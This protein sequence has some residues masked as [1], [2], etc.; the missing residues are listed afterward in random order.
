MRSILQNSLPLLGA[1]L[2][3]VLI[4]VTVL[5]IPLH[6]AQS[7]GLSSEQLT[8]WIVALYGIP[9]ILGIIL[10]VRF[11]QP[12]A[13]TSNLFA[14]IFFASLGGEFSWSELV[15]ASMLA[16]G[17]VVLIGVLGLAGPLARWIPTPIML[18]L[19]AG[20]VLPFIIDI[21]TALGDETL[22]VG[23]AL[24]AYLVG[25]RFLS[26][27]LPP[28][29]PAIVVGLLVAGLAGKLGPVPTDWAFP[30]PSI[31]TPT[32]SLSAIATVTPVVT[33]LMTLQAN[34]PSAIFMRNQGYEPPERQV[35]VVSGA[36]TLLGSLLGPTAVS[37]SLPLTSL[38]AGPD[39]GQHSLRHWSV[40]LTG[41][42]LVVVALL[43]VIALALADFIP[44]PLLLTLA[45]LA[46]F[47][48]L[49]PALQ[50]MAKGPLLIGPVF[51]FAITLSDLSLLGLGPFFWA[52]ILGIGASLLLE[53]DELK[54]LRQEARM[55][56]QHLEHWG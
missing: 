3:A 13:L 2:P 5:S 23:S 33:V 18:G 39:A 49:V 43:A 56:T 45:G 41:G 7:L 16:G 34:M 1:S 14:I 9:G 19:L 11:R 42:A 44:R 47:S 10:A 30:T 26:A 25:R 24:I 27:H 40:Y 36:G 35:N 4:F 32:F 53:R 46:M 54:V 8:M 38:L 37:M 22:T 52:L 20:A 29:L 17:V 15:G 48:L 55:N 12:L 21:F 31:T 51:T 50:Q 6:A 28:V